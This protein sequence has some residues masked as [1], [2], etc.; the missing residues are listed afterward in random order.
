MRNALIARAVRDDSLMSTEFF[1]KRA[2]SDI[3]NA[4]AHS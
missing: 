4:T 3:A 1:E 2:L